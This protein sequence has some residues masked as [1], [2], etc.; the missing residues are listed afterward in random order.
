MLP[1]TERF[2]DRVAD[3]VR[4][5]PSYPNEV[6]ALLQEECRID[7]DSFVADIGCG[8]GI[9]TQQLLAIGCLVVGVEPNEPM[10]EAAIANLANHSQFLA[11]EASGE[12]TGLADHC[13]DLVT[14]AQAF[15]WMDPS[16]ARL[17][18]M[19]ILK[20]KGWVALIWNERVSSGSEFLEGYE[21]VIRDF[22]PEY[23]FVK[24]R[25]QAD[26]SILAWFENSEA[27]VHSFEN[28][29]LIDLNG[30]LGR[31]F[32]SSYVPAEGTDG[33]R[34]IENALTNL[35]ASTQQGGLVSLEYETKVFLGQ[36]I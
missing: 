23:A 14:V 29:Q 6:V 2:S 9:F 30:L 20:P 28:N 15:H 4:A 22:A 16:E 33:R 7:S 19:R 25:N 35:F 26:D 11:V 32:S 34:K 8:T 18:F 5:R 3:Y 10:L 12:S 31:A 21:R 13:V 17:E 27:E 1:P 24:H 36:L